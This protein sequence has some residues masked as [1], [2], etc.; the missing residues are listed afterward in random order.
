[1]LVCVMHIS[2]EKADR[3][4]LLRRLAHI[5]DLHPAETG[6]LVDDDVISKD[7]DLADSDDGF[8]DVQR[9]ELPVHYARHDILIQ[10][11]T[12]VEHVSRL[13][14]LCT[15]AH[16]HTPGGEVAGKT[17]APRALVEIFR[18]A[19]QALGLSWVK[20]GDPDQFLC[21]RVGSAQ[22]LAPHDH[23]ISPRN[24]G[25][26]HSSKGLIQVN[27]LPSDQEAFHFDFILWALPPNRLRGAAGGYSS[28]A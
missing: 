10:E 23:G 19:R 18:T 14:P 22:R 15:E 11:L 9:I 4:V 1:M 12:R 24:G 2:N 16:I 27:V 21:G 28:A 17:G 7:I 26:A 13:A 20:L 25:I 5:C 8:A 3:R 6:M